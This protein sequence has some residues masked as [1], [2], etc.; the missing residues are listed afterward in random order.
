MDFYS[1]LKSILKGEKNKV[2][3]EEFNLYVIRS[4]GSIVCADGKPGD[5]QAIG[6]L[7]CGAWQAARSL[8]GKEE[9]TDF[10]LSFGTSSSGVYVL[11]LMLDG[12]RL[13]LVIVFE[14]VVNLG[15]L[16]IKMRKMRNILNE[17]LNGFYP[18][19]LSKDSALFDDISDDEVN[20]LFSFGDG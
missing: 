6:A 14:N 7:V 13:Y 1:D 5:Y 10:R 17:R 20:N 11:S 3:L 15:R 8:L 2:G 16:K 9:S 18:E 19:E 12:Y 4:D